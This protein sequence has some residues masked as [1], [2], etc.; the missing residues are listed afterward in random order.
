MARGVNKVILIGNLGGDP[1]VRYTPGGAAVANATLATNESWNDREGQRQE[2]TEWHR[3]VFWSK[4]A[5]IVGQY[6]KKGSKI[7]I[8]GRL[9]TRS[10][11]DQSGQKK[12]T[13]E[14][15]VTDMQ[16]LDGRGD[17]A[18]GGGGSMG[19]APGGGGFAGGGPPA[20]GGDFGQTDFG[21]PDGGQPGGGPSG[22]APSGGAPSGGGPSGGGGEA[23]TEDDDL[24]F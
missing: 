20:G 14:V 12:Y 8:E 13:T 18:M 6:L 11:D 21:Q 19:G 1:E 4:L 9:Q 7:Y 5:E 15:V 17:G 22:G 24:P 3:L 2:R 16:M 23:T 10:W